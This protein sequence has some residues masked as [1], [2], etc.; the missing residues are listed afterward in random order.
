MLNC[1]QTQQRIL[2]Q[3][4]LHKVIKA[5][6]TD[7]RRGIAGSVCSVSG[8]IVVAVDCV[9]YFVHVIQILESDIGPESTSV[10]DYVC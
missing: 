4:Q 8:A 7:K 2:R 1:R 10:D 3:V 6:R 9:Y 5:T